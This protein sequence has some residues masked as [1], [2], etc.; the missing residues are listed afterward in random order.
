MP[1][2][3]SKP[4]PLD[5]AAEAR[6]LRLKRARW[7]IAKDKGWAPFVIFHDSVLREIALTAPRDMVSLAQISGVGPKKLEQFGSAMLQALTES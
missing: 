3:V 7:Q 6:F 4:P 5:T 2:T 1:L